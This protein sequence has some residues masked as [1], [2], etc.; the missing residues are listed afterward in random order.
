MNKDLIDTATE[1]LQKELRQRLKSYTYYK[2]YCCVCKRYL[3]S[4][5]VQ[6]RIIIHFECR[7][8]PVIFQNTFSKPSIPAS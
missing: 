7:N 1:N 4:F 3:G 5:T 8:K 6:T 2:H